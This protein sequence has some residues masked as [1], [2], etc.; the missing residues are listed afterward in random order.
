M[1]SKNVG[2]LRAYDEQVFM[3]DKVQISIKS[4]KYQMET[5]ITQLTQLRKES[6]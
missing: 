2:Y 3:G 1:S 6:T 4:S 5:S